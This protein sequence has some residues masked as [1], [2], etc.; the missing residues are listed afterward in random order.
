MPAT[1]TIDAFPDIEISG[2]VGAVAPFA[3]ELGWQSLRRGFEVTIELDE[4]PSD[5]TLVP[6]MSVRVDVPLDG[7]DDAV[8][9]PRAALEILGD[10]ARALTSSGWEEVKLGICDALECVVLEGLEVGDRL[11]PVLE[12]ES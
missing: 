2:A 10:G 5:S 8:L 7:V 11:R 9:A 1:C 12:P 4:V 6:G 3:Q